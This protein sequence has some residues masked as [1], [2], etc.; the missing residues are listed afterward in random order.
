[1]AVH[2]TFEFSSALQTVEIYTPVRDE[3]GN[4]TALN[5]ESVFYD[6]EAF[7]E[8][9]RIVRNYQRMSSFKEGDPYTF[10]ECIPSIYPIDGIATPVSPGQVIE[11]EIP[12]MYGRPWAR[13]WE[14]YFEDGMQQPDDGDIFD[15][16]Q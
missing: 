14:K 2:A 16:S 12:D 11:Y 4:V 7:V 9:I 10:V 15:F 1:M 5:H 6:P 8:P 3:D 13:I